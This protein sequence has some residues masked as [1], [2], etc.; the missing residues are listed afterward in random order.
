MINNKLTNKNLALECLVALVMLA[1]WFLAVPSFVFAILLWLCNEDLFKSFN[2]FMFD[3]VLC[4]IFYMA[5][6]WREKNKTHD[7]PVQQNQMPK[8][9]PQTGLCPNTSLA[10]P[11]CNAIPQSDVIPGTLISIPQGEVIPVTMISTIAASANSLEHSRVV[12]VSSEVTS[13]QNF[14]RGHE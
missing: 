5:A 3:A 12:P 13:S 9:N 8:V 1:F 10:Q 11:S 7:C 4:L 2:Y 6:R 14:D